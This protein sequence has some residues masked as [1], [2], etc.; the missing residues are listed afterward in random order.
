ALLYDGEEFYPCTDVPPIQLSS[1]AEAERKTPTGWVTAVYGA[2]RAGDGSWLYGW[3][4]SAHRHR[5][6]PVVLHLEK[7]S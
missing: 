4:V 2:V 3:A 5:D 6:E 1:V 7:V